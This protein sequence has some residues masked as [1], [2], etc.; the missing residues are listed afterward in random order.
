MCTHVSYV[1]V[2][3]KSSHH[4]FAEYVYVFSE[5]TFK[6]PNP[7]SVQINNSKYL[8]WTTYIHVRTYGS[9]LAVCTIV[10]VVSIQDY[11]L[12]L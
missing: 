3:Y 8:Y 4:A 5:Q 2:V 6:S 9:I 7:L 1:L 11:P 10:N 12:Q